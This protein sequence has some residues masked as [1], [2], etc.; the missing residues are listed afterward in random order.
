MKLTGGGGYIYAQVFDVM[1]G[2]ICEK[3]PEVH[4]NFIDVQF[5]VSGKERLGFTVDTGDYIIDEQIKERDLIFYKD[6]RNE[7]FVEAVPGYFCVFFPSDVHRP[8]VASGEPM[9]IRKVVIKINK[10]LLD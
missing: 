10:K 6:I 4:E 3:R 5:L 1:T 7:G 2:D 9:Q 8:A